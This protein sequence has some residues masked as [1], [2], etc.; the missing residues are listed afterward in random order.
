MKEPQQRLFF[1]L[2]PD[3]EVKDQLVEAA[4]SI[5][6]AKRGRFMRKANLHMTLHF[7]GN[8]DPENAKCLQ[9]VAAKV[10]S[11]PFSLQIDKAGQFKRTGIVWLGCSSVPSELNEL[12]HRLGQ[13]ISSCDYQPEKR[14]YRPHVTLFRKAALAETESDI[15]SI[16][17]QVK[18]FS[19]ISSEQDSQGVIYR[20]LQRYPFNG[21]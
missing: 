4:R 19:L 8:T 10:V 3:D 18:S 12:H 13:V 20:E 7:I 14:H 1:A 6:L 9:E 16:N 2:W 11:Q 15:S 5:Q 17:W 21:C